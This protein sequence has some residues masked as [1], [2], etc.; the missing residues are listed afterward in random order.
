MYTQHVCLFFLQVAEIQNHIYILAWQNLLMSELPPQLLVHF[1]YPN[2]K[3]I[4]QGNG[5]YLWN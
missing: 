2:K 4:A 5:F 3:L 1:G